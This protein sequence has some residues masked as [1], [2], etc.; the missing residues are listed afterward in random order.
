MGTLAILVLAVSLTVIPPLVDR[1]ALPRGASPET[2]AAL[3]AVT[4]VGV[5][6]VPLTLAICAG[7]L[8][9]DHHTDT[10]LNLLAVTGLLLVAVAAG[11]TVARIVRIRR[12]WAALS[13]LAAALDLP[14]EPGGARILPLGELLAF[15]SG[16]EAF[17]SQGLIDQLTPPQRQAVIEHEREHV[18]G[19]HARLLATASA[20]THAAFGVHPARHAAAVLDRELDLLADRAAARRVGDPRVV[21]EALRAAAV[22]G[23]GR[24]LDSATRARIERLS[25]G[26]PKG[27]PL[28]DT[29][30]R[31]AALALGALL[32]ASIC[33][34]V[35][36]GSAWFGVIACLLFLAGFASLTAPAL[37][38]KRPH[39]KQKEMTHA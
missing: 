7:F 33:L 25:C 5:A 38:P 16:S 11:R 24:D 32:L 37:R 13:R 2:L 3:A 6:A 29:A 8:A 19:R 17:V 18:R 36:T 30:V 28:I 1:W 26:E 15:V 34:A 23:A 35:H 4:L 20:L 14:R 10:G 22:P 31:L 21:R 27:R 9:A 12:R 39:R